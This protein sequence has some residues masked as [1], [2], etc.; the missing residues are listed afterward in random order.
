MTNWHLVS[1]VDVG[2]QFKENHGTIKCQSYRTGRTSY[3][4]SRAS[5]GRQ[6]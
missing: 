5:R 3:T 4:A 2:E 6:N 1:D